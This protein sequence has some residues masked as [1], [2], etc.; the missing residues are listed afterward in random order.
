MDMTLT[1]RNLKQ[2]G[3]NTLNSLLEELG[4]DK[5]YVLSVRLDKG[6]GKALEEQEKVWGMKSVGSA[7]RTILS[8]YFLPAVYQ[9]EWKR[10]EVQHFQN[11]LLQQKMEGISGEQMKIN[12]FLKAL[13]EYLNFLEQT[14]QASEN[15]LKFAQETQEEV[16]NAI[17]EMREKIQQALKEMEQVKK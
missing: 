14:K 8:F 9:L 1:D 15:T 4:H 17:M 2:A 11:A 13:F 10:K 12:Y 5:E 6:L 16:N 7:L 3:E